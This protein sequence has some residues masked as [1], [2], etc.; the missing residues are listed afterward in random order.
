MPLTDRN[1]VQT[2]AT[3]RRF[4]GGLA[5]EFIDC[6][7]GSVGLIFDYD[8]ERFIEP[9]GLVIRPMG[10]NTTSIEVTRIDR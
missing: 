7:R 5:N 2:L 8:K 6:T 1:C 9:D 4:A 3:A 10:A